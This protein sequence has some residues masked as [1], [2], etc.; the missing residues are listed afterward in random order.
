MSDDED[1]QPFEYENE[2]LQKQKGKS[3]LA[4]P[5]A[6]TQSKL[7]FKKAPKPA[8]DSDD[9]D[10]DDEFG[11]S[12]M[13]K[14]PKKNPDAP[15][16]AKISSALE[17]GGSDEK[18]KKS[19]AIEN[20]I[21]VRNKWPRG[22]V[23][24]PAGWEAREYKDTPKGKEYWVFS[25]ALWGETKNQEHTKRS[26]EDWSAIKQRTGGGSKRRMSEGGG[27][28]GQ[29]SGGASSHAP[30]GSGGGDADAD[31]GSGCGEAV[32][33][34]DDPLAAL[35]N[36]KRR[37]EEEEEEMRERVHEE[38]RMRMDTGVRVNPALKKMLS[39]E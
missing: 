5:K 20:R 12:V 29:G 27:S 1:K 10:D 16:E 3:L 31:G 36:K 4:K 25:H 8:A 26:D 18:K 9:D 38:M 2:A 24:L 37:K 32:N 13:F 7:G 6:T 23:P 19:D 35:L 28:G 14:A 30:G 34:D 21:L 11:S 17:G 22:K 15:A 33:D 39:G